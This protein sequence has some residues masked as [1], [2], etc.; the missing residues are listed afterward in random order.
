ME[1]RNLQAS[2]P[3]QRPLHL[4]AKEWPDPT[5][6]S[7]EAWYAEDN[8]ELALFVARNEDWS[9][10]IPIDVAP[11]SVEGWF[12][13]TDEST[14]PTDAPIET[15]LCISDERSSCGEVVDGE[16]RVPLPNVP[17][18]STVAVIQVEWN[19]TDVG[20]PGVPLVARLSWTV[21]FT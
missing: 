7:V 14:T 12:Y 21:G 4:V 8:S 1:S 18:R 13:V 3:A 19:T 9:L 6:S 2:A 20:M 11:A 10:A 5:G 16:L 15:W 17:N